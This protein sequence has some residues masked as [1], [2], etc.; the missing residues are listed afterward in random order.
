MRIVIKYFL[1]T[2]GDYRLD[3]AETL[4]C[5]AMNEADEYGD[6]FDYIGFAEFQSSMDWR[7]KSDAKDFLWRFLCDGIRVSYTHA[8]LIKDFYNIIDDLTDQI[9]LFDRGSAGMRRRLTGNHSATRIE[10]EMTDN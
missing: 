9:G 10:I 6:Y 7:C 5:T 4:G 1:Y 8:W 3:N 2:D